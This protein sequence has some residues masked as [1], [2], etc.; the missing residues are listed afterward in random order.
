MS[1]TTFMHYRKYDRYGQIVCK[2]GLTLAIQQ[3]N[4]KL[5]VALAQCGKKDHF[6]RKIGRN[7]ASGRLTA[8]SEKNRYY[9]TLPPETSMKSFIHNQEFVRERVQKLLGG[10]K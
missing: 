3:E 6:N 7:I 9:L 4:D 2:G 8:G 1:N 10:K 5:V